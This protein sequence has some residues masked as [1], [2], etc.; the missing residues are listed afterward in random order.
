MGSLVPWKSMQKDRKFI[1]WAPNFVDKIFLDILI[2]WLSSLSHDQYKSQDKRLTGCT[3]FLFVKRN[4]NE[5]IGSVS[6]L[7][8][9]MFVSYKV[10]SLFYDVLVSKYEKKSA[11]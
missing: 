8:S 6:L 10:S 1:F 7:F 11:L 3:V 5:A 4:K 2:T 9:I